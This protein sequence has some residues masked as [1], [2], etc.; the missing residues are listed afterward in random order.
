MNELT[1]KQKKFLR[2]LGQRLT[3]SVIIGVVAAT[4][5]AVGMVFG[6]KLGARFGKRMELIG[7]LVLIG[8]GVKIVIEHLA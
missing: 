3:P 6:R 1:G 5:T 7:G 2:G 4:M 8:I